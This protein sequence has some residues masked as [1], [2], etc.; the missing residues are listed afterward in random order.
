MPHNM[1][2]NEIMLMT[3][4]LYF[5]PLVSQDVSYV[6]IVIIFIISSLLFFLSLGIIASKF[7]F[8]TFSKTY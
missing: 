6:C 2:V 3:S 4:S 1:L 7:S 8:M 5:I